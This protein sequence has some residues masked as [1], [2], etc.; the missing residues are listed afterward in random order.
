MR[1][2]FA[3]TVRWLEEDRSFALATLVELR[4]ARTAPLGTTLAV[5]ASGRIAGNIGAG[6]YESEIV[7]AAIATAAD[8]RTRALAINLAEDDVLLGGTACGAM[9]ELVVWRPDAGF[10]DDARAIADGERE[11]VMTLPYDRAGSPR[12]FEHVFA[13]RDTLIVVGATS[14][15]AEVAAIAARAD[16]KVVVVDP[17]P[18]FATRERVPDAHEIAL[19]WPDEYLPRVL[20]PRTSVLAL[21][22][23]PK[24]DIPALRCALDSPAPYVGLLGSRRAQAARREAL[25]EAGVG[26]E[27]IA[28]IHGPAGLDIGGATAAETAISILAELIAV[29][30]RGSG[31]PLA[32][33]RGAIHPHLRDV[34]SAESRPAAPTS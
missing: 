31:A 3:Q 12:T 9:M 13:A 24:L 4:E 11:V 20:G 2:V 21:S 23:D 16:F 8:G 18:A 25:R 28:R 22:H 6:C 14:L 33:S 10:L 27:A 17:R 15:A 34:S 7:Q 1:D 29:A 26:E 5:D 19:E 32:T 30:H